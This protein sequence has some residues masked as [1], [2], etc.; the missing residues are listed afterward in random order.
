MIL[1]LKRQKGDQFLKD[2]ESLVVEKVRL[3]KQSPL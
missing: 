3:S 2:F 1:N